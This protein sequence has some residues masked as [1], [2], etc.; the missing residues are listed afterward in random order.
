MKVLDPG[1]VHALSIGDLI[2]FESGTVLKDSPAALVA[3]LVAAAWPIVKNKEFGRVLE[4]IESAA[5]S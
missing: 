4:Q 5:C 3:E 1:K 2:V